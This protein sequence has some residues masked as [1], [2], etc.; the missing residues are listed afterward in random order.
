MSRP[1]PSRH[2]VGPW[3][4]EACDT[5]LCVASEEPPSPPVSAP[6]PALWASSRPARPPCPAEPVP[7]HVHPALPAPPPSLPGLGPPLH[8]A[9]AL[10]RLR[11]ALLSGK[12]CRTGPRL[13]ALSPH[14]CGMSSPGTRI[15]QTRAAA[16]PPPPPRGQLLA[17]P[18][19]GSLRPHPSCLPHAL[20]SPG[21]RVHAAGK[22]LGSRAQT[23]GCP[24]GRSGPNPPAPSRADAL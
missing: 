16:A 22:A 7:C 13:V 2:R 10:T 9:R 8:M 14:S 18:R 5:T 4:P 17:P 1:R 20:T 12:A 6:R 23:W 24:G 19:L 15:P 3:S 21:S 11:P